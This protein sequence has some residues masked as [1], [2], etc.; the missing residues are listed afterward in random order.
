[1]E[2]KHVWSFSIYIVIFYVNLLSCGI[3]NVTVDWSFSIY[4]VIFYVNL[5]S[6]GIGNVTVDGVWIGYSIY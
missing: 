1:M 2:S 6:C 3:G 4:I 5:L